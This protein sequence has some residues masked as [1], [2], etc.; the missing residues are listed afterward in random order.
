VPPTF[1]ILLFSPLGELVKNPSLMFVSTVL[2]LACSSKQPTEDAGQKNDDA[3]T[4]VV[5]PLGDALSDLSLPE[6]P[7][8]D[9]QRPPDM[10]SMMCVDTDG[11]GLSNDV[12]GAPRV[13]TDRDGM[14]DYMD[15]DSDNDGFT[16]QQ[17]ATRSYPMYDS[18]R[19]PLMCGQQANNCDGIL[20]DS[21]DV[22]PNF[23]DLDSDNDGLTDREER[24]ANTDPC[25]GDTDGDGVTDLVE[26]SAM[27]DPRDRM[28]GPPATALYVVLPYVAPPRMGMHE[29]REF[30]F[31][32]RIRQADVFFLVDNSSS[33]RPVIDNLRTNLRSVIVPGIRAQITDIQ[34]GVGSFDSMPISPQGEPGRMGTAGDYTLWVR[35]RVTSDI[36]AVQGAFDTM[37]TIDEDTMG[38]YVG[39][40]EPEC[41]TEAA[42]QV[43]DGAG[44][45]GHETDAPALLSVRNARD[46][47]GNGWVPRVDP[48]RDCASSATNPRYGWGCFNEGRVPIVVLAS[49]A[50]WY[51]GC[52]PTSPRTPSGLG[53]DCS[54]IVAAYNRRG[55]LFIGIDVGDGV[56]GRTWRNAQPLA[57]MTRTLNGA[58]SPIVFGPGAM[59]IAGVSSSVVDAIT[60]IAGQTRQDIT[61]RVVPDR[62]A[63]GLP[64]GRTTAN[65]VR[66][67]TPARAEPGMP[68]GF[69]RL[70]MTTFYNVSPTARV[71]FRA[72]FYNDFMPG[73]MSARLF[74]A[75]IEV[76]GRGGSVVDT[77]PLFIVVPAEGGILP[78]G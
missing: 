75:T 28:S 69:E 34:M 72:D 35:Q 36:A 58:G 12:E 76:L 46:P 50:R 27:S 62:M 44:V 10:S 64:M 1:L 19:T 78:P 14:P 31:S 17:E 51:D 63:M 45:R 25:S 55:A 43:V 70:D 37:R 65:F 23:R 38:L 11:D 57:R 9:V 13:D 16:D 42:F 60:Q 7:M 54:E 26:R 59:G 56:E 66:S 18:A 67:V 48:V 68:T 3:T 49:D 39:G 32:T 53:H 61:T 71:V 2:L 21:G 73:G 30:T 74:N 20:G 24:E 52:D 29:I 4:D 5:I 8:F 6:T 47:M 33:M 22:I 77:R 40:N 41:Q 15:T